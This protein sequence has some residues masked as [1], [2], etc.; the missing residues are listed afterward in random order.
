MPNGIGK[1]EEINAKEDNDELFKD[2]DYVV[3]E[4]AKTATLT[5]AGVEKA[6]KY[7][8]IQFR[9]PQI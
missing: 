6:E 2:S 1:K 8:C 4:K 5:P 7:F 3:D 9:I